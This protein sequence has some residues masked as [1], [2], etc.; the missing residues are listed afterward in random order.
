MGRRLLD[1]R[2]ALRG[3]RKSPTFAF[4]AVACLGLA[5]GA[6]TAL[7]AIFNTL[8]WKP[9]PAA[10]P[11]A[12]VRIFAKGPGPGRLYQGFSYPEYLDYRT[13]VPVLAGLLATTGVEVGFRAGGADAMRA[14]GEA[15]TDGYFEVLGVRPYLGRFLS[16][17]P[18]AG[19]SSASEVVLGYR[20]WE[21]RLHADPDVVGKTVWLTG[22]PFSVV[23]IAPRG[24]NG[25]YPSP[26][27][28]PE[29][30]LPLGSAGPLEGAGSRVEDRAVRSLG[31]LGR[32]RAG[33]DLAQAQA[34]V[35]TVASRLERSYPDSNKGVM[36]LVFRELDTH[37][38]VYSSRPLNQVAFLFLGL[39]GLVLVVACA[40][41]ANLVLARGA[42]RRKEMALRVA[43]G[44]GRWQLVRQLVTE[45][46]VLAFLAAGVGLLVGYAVTRAASSVRLPMDVPLAFDPR[47]D[48]RACWFT[49]ATALASGLAFGLLPALGASK[50]DLVPALKGG[51]PANRRRRWFG[52]TNLL[53]VAQVAV[54]LVLVAAAGLFWRSIAGA[55]AIDPGMQ[56]ADRT[57]VSFTPSLLRYDASR[58]AAFYKTLLER[59]A[60]APELRDAA[61]VKWVPLGFSFDEEEF[62]VQ[63]AE[64][65]AG[66]KGHRSLVNTVTPTF[67][68]AAG[69]SVRRGRPFSDL[70]TPDS[71]PV[72]IVN[73]TLAAREWPGRDAV[74]QRLRAGA[75]GAPWLTV[76]GVVSDGKYRTLTEPPQPCLFRPLSQRPASR[77]TLVV[78][79]DRGHAEALAAV[80]REVHALDPAMPLL[81]V[82]T[83][84]QQMA[85]ARF[86]PQAM[87]ALAG[88]A[89]ALAILIAA[90]GLYGVIAYSVGRRTREFGVRLAIGARPGRVVWHVFGRAMWIVAAGLAAGGAAALALARVMR[91]L[92]VGVTATDPLVFLATFGLLGAVASLAIY[93]PA[94]AASRVDPLVAL[95][96]E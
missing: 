22:V 30:W 53:V 14:Y 1:V 80:R 83:M 62:V 34:A 27:F 54:S 28:A 94:R 41:L 72:A 88:P 75:E 43:L 32:L 36:A 40:N 33:A 4:T 44:A 17:T 61:L 63:G 85:K 48:L 29:L 59:A 35:A 5:L 16:A 46:T 92:L 86:L 38:E 2:H 24:F 90:L 6:N 39:A 69:V 79:S 31:L 26:I 18:G 15:V 67:F 52:L 20:F 55:G 45:S 77:L 13:Q 66:H 65:Q 81:D 74:G 8:L 71:L 76:V 49:L 12:L 47:L 58:A 3:L 57:L 42:A 78:R 51:A 96:M 91:G 37:P 82:K 93:I 11:G 21:R 68:Q 23:G 50:P 19:E 89:A 7:F 70:D 60:Q 73:E 10:D 84:D 25:T 56:L 87:T 64:L 95:R 9:M